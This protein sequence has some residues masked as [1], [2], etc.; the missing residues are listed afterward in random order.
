M[1]RLN[2]L[3]NSMRARLVSI[4]NWLYDCSHRKTTFPITLR[5]GSGTASLGAP[6]ET[7]IVC[8]DCGRHLSYDWPTM[9]RTKTSSAWVRRQMA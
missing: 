9:R 4:A 8:L 5:A 1:N 7:Y 3:A 2:V 6:I